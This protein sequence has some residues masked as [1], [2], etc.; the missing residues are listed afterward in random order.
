MRYPSSLESSVSSTTHTVEASKK[1]PRIY[2]REAVLFGCIVLLVLF[3]LTTAAVSRMYHKKI[4]VLADAWFALG[5]AAFEAGDIKSALIDY[6]NALVYSPGNA[7]FQFHLAQALAAAGRGDEARSYLLYLLS[8]SPGSGEVNLALARIAARKG[9]TPEALRYYHG[10]IYGEWESDPIAMRWQVRRELSEYLLDRG[11]EKQA[12]PEI[13]ALADNT[14]A[15]DAAHRRIV[16]HLLL[17]AKLWTRA[18]DVFRSLISANEQDEDALLGAA[19]SAFELSRCSLALDYFDRLPPQKRAEPEIAEM[20]QT[21]REIK[22]MDPFVPGLSRE[23]KARRA[24]DG[25]SLAA[26]RLQECADREGQSLLV[27]PPQTP[28]QKAFM[29]GKELETRGSLQYLE[30][31]PE[32]IEDVM[33]DVFE[34]ENVAAA[35]CG[36]PQGSDRALWL[37]GRSRGVPGQ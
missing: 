20:Y 7:N 4:H 24:A 6:R 35:A 8:E 28:L 26:K 33:A 27:T 9:T 21:A 14:P 16:G 17:R 37:L 10:A 30:K 2:S 25:L 1:V 34:M 29:D 22:E 15:D 18:L 11:E 12:V 19:V 23:A 32:T 5:Q 31:H 36:E 13:I 3:I